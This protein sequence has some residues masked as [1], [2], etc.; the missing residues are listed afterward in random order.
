MALIK[1]IEEF[2]QFIPVNTTF[3][4]EKIH[5]ILMDVQRDVFETYCGKLLI[6]SLDVAYKE[7][8]ANAMDTKDQALLDHIRPALATIALCRYLPI[9]ELQVDNAGISTFG[10]SSTRKG[11]DG[12]QIV[13]LRNSLLSIGMNAFERLLTF[14]E[15]NIID[16]PLHQVILDKKPKSLLPNARVFSEAYQIFDSHLTY[17]GLSSILSRIE[18]DVVAEKIGVHYP[19]LLLNDSLP[20]PLAAIRR[21]AQRALAYLVVADAIEINMAI[22]LSAE[23]LRLNYSSE[24]GNL[25]YYKAPGDRTRETVLAAAKRKADGLLEQ[26]QNSLDALNGN[27]DSGSGLPDNEDSKI[28]MFS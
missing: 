11:A 15:E 10:E 4:Y 16:Y 23:G 13:R 8:L 7:K 22:D 28:I 24:F 2:K 25:P 14:L 6:S 9:G 17:R 1:D 21:K 27:I 5:P 12:N 26:L 18:E 3:S 19:A 20:E